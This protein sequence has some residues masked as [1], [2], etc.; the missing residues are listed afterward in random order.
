MRMYYLKGHDFVEYHNE[1][2]LNNIGSV[3]SQS[4][5]CDFDANLRVQHLFLFLTFD[6]KNLKKVDLLLYTCHLK[7]KLSYFYEL[8]VSF[9]ILA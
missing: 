3:F 2:H 8:S 5:N 1:M 6:K 9:M 4:T 7:N